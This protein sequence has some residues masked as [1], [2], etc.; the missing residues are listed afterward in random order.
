M[1]ETFANPA[2]LAQA[3]A[4]AVQ[5]ALSAAIAERGAAVLVATGGRS[6]APV[7]DLLAQAPIDWGSVT[8]TLSDDRFVAPTSPDSNERLVRDRLLVAKA[9]SARFTPL[10]F[11]VANVREAALRAEPE[12]K[13]LAP[14]DVMLLGMGEDGHVASLIPGSPVMDEGINPAGERFC[15]GVPAGVGSPPVARVTM[16]M[17]ALLQARLTL[18]LISG[19]TKREIIESGGGLPVHA[20]LEQAK[21]P[22]R[23]L[24]TP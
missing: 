20:L 23:V 1:L 10:S 22:V 21:A 4:A 14:Y 24:W 11:D 18:V 6:P 13:A 17:P 3:A 19:E 16:T 12:V 5:A 8:V 15:L 9:A 2:H 7:Y